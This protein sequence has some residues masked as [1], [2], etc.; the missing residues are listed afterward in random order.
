MFTREFKL[1]EV[2]RVSEHGVKVVQA[3]RDLGIGRTCSAVGFVKRPLGK[4]A[5]FPDA[6]CSSVNADV[7][8]TRVAEVKLTHLGED[9]GFGTAYVDPGAVRGD[10]GVVSARQEHQRDCQGAWG[11][12]E[13]GARAPA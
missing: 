3:A 2:K 12:A 1:E 13:H 9:G 7:K 8:L 6:G 11:V 10:S 4:A 5:L